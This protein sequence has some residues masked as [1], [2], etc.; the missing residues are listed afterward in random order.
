MHHTAERYRPDKVIGFRIQIG[1]TL[2][3]DAE[4]MPGIINGVPV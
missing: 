4:V 3:S 2:K 1:L